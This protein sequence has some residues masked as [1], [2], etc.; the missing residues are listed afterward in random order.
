V[1]RRPGARRT[2]RVVERAGARRT[3]RVVERAGPNDDPGPAPLALG[4]A[5]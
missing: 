3:R 2:R 5:W 1:A 4:G